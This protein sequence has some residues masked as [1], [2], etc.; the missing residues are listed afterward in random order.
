MG[1]GTVDPQMICNHKEAKPSKYFPQVLEPIIR[2]NW[3][4][5]DNFEKSRTPLHFNLVH[6]NRV[7]TEY[8]KTTSIYSSREILIS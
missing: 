3:P 1:L 6:L 4:N 7:K 5:V 8:N 2:E